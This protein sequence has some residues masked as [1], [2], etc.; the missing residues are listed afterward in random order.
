[1]GVTYQNTFTDLERLSEHIVKN[2]NHGRKFAAQMFL[3][4]MAPV[5]CI[6]LV[7]AVYGKWTYALLGFFVAAG[8]FWSARKKAFIQALKKQYNKPAFDY[9]WHPVT[10]TLTDE[11][12]KTKRESG[13]GFYRWPMV[14]HVATDD[15]YVFY[16]MRGIGNFAVPSQDFKSPQEKDAFFR[17]IQA[18]VSIPDRSF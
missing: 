10:V 16:I 15:R 11:G 14:D 3:R 6:C 1:M 12:L 17:S 18:H 7:L 13:E 5:T 4:F 2:T 8:I 9:F